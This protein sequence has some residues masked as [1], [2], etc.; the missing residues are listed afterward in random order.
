MENINE[1]VRYRLEKLERL[2]NIGV[3]PYPYRFE[4]SHGAAEIISEFDRLATSETTVRVAGRII[5][6]RSHGKTVFATIEDSSGK[7]QI[8]ARRD[9]LGE[10]W[11]FFELMD[12]GDIIG[13]E[14]TVFRTRMGEITVR[15]RQAEMLAKSLRPLPEKWHGLQDKELRY[16]QRYLD[17]I[18]T[19]EVKN[20]FIRRA[21][22]IR[23]LRRFLDDRGFIE[24]ETPV[25]QPLYGG[26]A[27]RPF[28]TH[29]N[30]L[31]IDLYLRI[32]DELYLKRLII[33]GFEKVY[34]LAKDFRNEGMDRLHNPE[35][36]MLEFYWA[37]AD[38]TDLMPFLEE[39]LRQISMVVS[40]TQVLKFGAHTIDLSKPFRRLSYFE[41]IK[42]S[43]GVDII[44]LSEAELG[45]L[46]LQLGLDVAGL[47]GR[48]DYFEA[49]FD[50]FVEPTLIQPTF[51][52]DFPVEL[53]PLA[54]VHRHDKR[55]AE[56]F[57]L[58]IAGFEFGNAFSEQND[59]HDQKKRME[60]HAALIERGHAE[61]APV[62]WDFINALEYGMPPTA[63]YGLGVD[64]L[65][66]LFTD[67]PSIRDVIL[68]PTMKP[69]S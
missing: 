65:V 46:A 36:T 56:R 39:M 20:N 30:A 12:I 22:V 37:Y 25:L 40:G 55:L 5:S 38:Y 15:V 9:D 58:F 6:I 69:E 16:R 61:A 54:K 26:A 45:K 64:R 23:E 51:L 67:S 63:G 34:E 28:I 18:A 43:C 24:V 27:A 35:F 62:D 48:G 8:Y 66:M 1:L 52:M 31:D 21:A 11:R 49:F 3:N 14:G 44:D 41:S 4:K 10:N 33:G 42:E 2:R 68:F 60:E 19:P 13:V 57:E 47:K 53:S 29:H 59:P 32:A 7:I 17:L 50:K